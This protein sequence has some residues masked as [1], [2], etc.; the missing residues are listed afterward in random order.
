MASQDDISLQIWRVAVNIPLR[1]LFDYLPPRDFS[2]R[3][4]RFKAGVRVRVP[5]GKR[6][7]IGILHSVHDK[8]EASVV[9]QKLKPILEV[10]DNEPII[11]ESILHLCRFASEYYQHPIGE[12]I[13]CSLPTAL[14]QGKATTM[15]LAHFYKRTD[16]E[17]KLRKDAYKQLSTM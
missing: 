11:S 3:R 10:L 15:G 1:R 8:S 17:L 7:I 9:P 4:R 6:Q 12:V 13:A 5:F 14:R 16:K 2:L